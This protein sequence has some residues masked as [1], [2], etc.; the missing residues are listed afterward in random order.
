MRGQC[1]I[2]G[3]LYPSQVWTS[4][5]NVV[6]HVGNAITIIPLG[7][8]IIFDLGCAVA[9]PTALLSSEDHIFIGLF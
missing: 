2:H 1:F 5:Q 6:K 8:L 3:A 9:N 4:T 7:N